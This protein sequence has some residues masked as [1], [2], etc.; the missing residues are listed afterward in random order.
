MA[1]SAVPVNS[2]SPVPYR[3]QV[4][5]AVKKNKDLL[6]SDH[7]PEGTKEKYYRLDLY[8]P[9][10]DSNTH[11]PLIIWL[12]GG[13]FKFGTKR[14]AGTPVWSRDFALRG[15]VCAALNYRLSKKHPLKQAA[16]LVDGCAD[17]VEDL[18]QAIRFFVLNR[19][20]YGIDTS[21][22]ILGGNSAGAMIALQAGYSFPAEMRRL[23]HPDPSASQPAGTSNPLHIA[24]IINF[25]GAIFNPG[26]LQHASIPIV[27]ACGSRDRV[28][29]PD[30][31]KPPIYGSVVIHRTADSLHIPNRL[32][33]FENCGH[34]LQKHFNP[35]FAGW[36][37]H[38]RWR[39]AGQFAADF[40]FAQLFR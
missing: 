9:A 3:D 10:G 23:A 25:W 35:L 38:K 22:I 4:F 11:R 16:D 6:Y 14:S 39:E 19:E 13:G 33:V 7:R 2:Q 17:A 29:P 28:V 18:Q 8:S 34:E 31:A 27:A 15:Y 12:H 36:G 5:T 21:R 20:R 37:A 30:A 40:L 24:A 32:R 26:W 1:T